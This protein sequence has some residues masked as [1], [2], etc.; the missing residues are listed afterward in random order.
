MDFFDIVSSSD[1]SK[2]VSYSL[3]VGDFFLELAITNLMIT[4]TAISTASPM[5]K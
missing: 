1:Q 5:E 3:F 2:N 4:A